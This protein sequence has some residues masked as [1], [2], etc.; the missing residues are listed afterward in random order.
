MKFKC[1]NLT[2]IFVIS[3][4]YLSLS[5]CATVPITRESLISAFR[6][7]GDEELVRIDKSALQC[8]DDTSTLHTLIIPDSINLIDYKIKV[9]TK[10]ELGIG[11]KIIFTDEDGERKILS[12]GQ[13][14]G[15]IF[16][17][18]LNN[19]N[20]TYLANSTWL[21]G[22]CLRGLRSRILGIQ[23]FTKISN[24]ANAKIDDM[25]VRS[26]FSKFS[27]NDSELNMQDIARIQS[28]FLNSDSTIFE[29]DHV[30][31]D[32]DTTCLYRKRQ[33]SPR[34][35]ISFTIK[36]KKML[37]QVYNKISQAGPFFSPNSIQCI[38][39]DDTRFSKQYL[40]RIMFFPTGKFD[41]IDFRYNR[42]FLSIGK[43]SAITSSNVLN[44]IF[45][46]ITEG[47]R[48]PNI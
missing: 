15:L 38:G 46:I 42:N 13:K 20:E 3:V 47:H 48:K 9:A 29:F 24:L 25:P 34:E 35:K 4:V 12:V 1:I 27:V 22:G 43:K 7:C 23:Y 31:C 6:T 30:M 14:T 2:F 19:S 8:F 44:S 10:Y 16:V 11:S 21:Y 45:P 17:D 5:G 33:Y 28:W 39:L 37:Q 36:D 26:W 32:D 41:T 18:S 40:G